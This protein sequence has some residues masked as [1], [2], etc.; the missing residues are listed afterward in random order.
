MCTVDF[1]PP[2]WYVVERPKARKV[3]EC[4][5]CSR[6]ILRG[7]VYTQATG[8]WDGRISRMR[9][10]P[11]CT[12]LA[13]AV[14]AADCSWAWGTLSDDAHATLEGHEDADPVAYGTVAGLL[15]ARRERALCRWERG[16]T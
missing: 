12:A 9:H 8:S 3:H 15:F 5:D 14:E 6:G 10:C 2:D 11:E 4:E 16:T 7:E 1:D 13:K